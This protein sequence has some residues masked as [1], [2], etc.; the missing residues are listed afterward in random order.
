M[1]GGVKLPGYL[2]AGEH[3]L[4]IRA[5]QKRGRF[6]FSINICEPIDDILYSGNLYPGVRYFVRR[7][8]SGDQISRVVEADHIREDWF[9]PYF[10]SNLETLAEA[11]PE[12]GSGEVSEADGARI[13]KLVTHRDTWR[14]ARAAERSALAV[15]SKML[16]RPPLPPV[17]VDPLHHQDQGRRLA[18]WRADLSVGVYD[19]TLSGDTI[20]RKWIYGREPEGE[21]SDVLA[22][23]PH[24]AEWRIAVET[25]EGGGLYQVKEQPS[26]ENDWTTVLRIDDGM[27]WQN[28]TELMIWA[29]PM[30]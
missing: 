14:R 9:S 2:E 26:A 21:V 3:R 23:F 29:I 15:L 17:V 6:D 22:E 10:A 12:E 30:K 4:L 20:K 13:A 11:L 1:L 19:V 24:A 16:S 28:S 25:V 27:T 8:G 18:S 7:S 5:G